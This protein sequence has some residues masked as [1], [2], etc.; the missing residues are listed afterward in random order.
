MFS[1]EG[2]RGRQ[3]VVA[4]MRGSGKTTFVKHA[5][6]PVFR[7]HIV[8][9]L[10]EDYPPENFTVYKVPRDI[11]ADNEQIKANF[12]LLCSR[13]NW[14]VIDCVVVNEANRVMPNREKMPQYGRMLVDVSRHFEGG[15][16]TVIYETRRPAQLH[17]DVLELADIIVCFKLDGKND[18]DALNARRTGLG[19]MVAALSLDTHEAIVYISGHH[20]RRIEAIQ[21]R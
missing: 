13:I 3:I 1:K 5:L 8:Y 12:D 19:D 7:R 2:L 20:P 11:R 17:T 14:S 15:P 4:G 21:I 6:L 9:D 18:V 16:K 10:V